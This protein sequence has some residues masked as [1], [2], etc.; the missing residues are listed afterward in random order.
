[1]LRVGGLLS[2][3]ALSGA[4]GCDSKDAEKCEEALKVSRQSV[5]LDDFALAQQW[6]ERAW[7]NCADTNSLDALDKEIVAKKTAVEAKKQE[8]TQRKTQNEALLK[9][10]VDWA[11]ANRG[12]PDRASAAPKC[13]EPPAGAPPPKPAD[14]E[15]FCTGTRS[16]AEYTLTARYWDADKT[17]FRFTTRPKA[18]VTCDDLGANRVLKTWAVPAIDGRTVTRTRCE[19]TGG[20]LSG[21][22]AV[23]SAANNAEVYVFS[24]PYLQK[25]PAMAK[26]AGGP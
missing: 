19:L 6:R 10:F 13:D 1:M 7:K 2:L 20:G 14:K 21:L 4:T 25:D 9:L 18:P 8:E 23:V 15:R 22:Q 17:A 11:S 16:A 3:L 5:A 24:L 26:I 12:S